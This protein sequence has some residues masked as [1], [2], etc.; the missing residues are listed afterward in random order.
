MGHR[1]DVR[2]VAPVIA[3]VLTVAIVVVLTS[4]FGFVLF[5]FQSK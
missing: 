5:D 4:V 2:G 1:L 3:V